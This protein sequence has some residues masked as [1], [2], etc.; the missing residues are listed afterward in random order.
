MEIWTHTSPEIRLLVTPL[1][2]S[3]SSSL[4]SLVPSSTFVTVPTQGHSGSHCPCRDGNFLHVAKRVPTM[5]RRN[6]TAGDEMIEAISITI[7]ATVISP[8][9]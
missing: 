1:S 5:Q 2:S 3:A 7:V 4:P 6:T 9:P 8:L